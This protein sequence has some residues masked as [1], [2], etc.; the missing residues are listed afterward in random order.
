MLSSRQTTGFSGIHRARLAVIFYRVEEK[1]KSSDGPKDLPCWPIPPS[2]HSRTSKTSPQAP[3]K[4]THA[5]LTAAALSFTAMTTANAGVTLTIQ[6]NGA[7]GVTMMASGSI[8]VSTLSYSG[9]RTYTRPDDRNFGTSNFFA[10][11]PST[12]EEV[13]SHV[14]DTSFSSSFIS[15]D[16]IN[17]GAN[18]NGL[19]LSSLNLFIYDSSGTDDDLAPVQTV[20]NFDFVMTDNDGN[21]SQYTDGQVIWDSNG[22]GTSGGETITIQVIPEPSIALLGG[23]GGLLLLRRRR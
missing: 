20:F 8:D 7:G 15:Y 13:W 10:S 16:S 23:L 22:F 19:G 18:G 4:N 5:L 3:M 2:S 17:L 6:D 1:E 14:G 12:V 21:I 11:A 9:D